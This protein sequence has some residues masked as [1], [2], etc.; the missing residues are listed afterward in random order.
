MQAYGIDYTVKGKRYD[1]VIDAKSLQSANKKL[2]RKH[3][4]KSGRMIKIN[5][6]FIVGYY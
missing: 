3:G 4:Y 2:G 1:V 5:N 6:A